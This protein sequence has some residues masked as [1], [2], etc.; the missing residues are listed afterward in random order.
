MVISFWFLDSPPFT[1]KVAQCG[2][3]TMPCIQGA[4][5]ITEERDFQMRSIHLSRWVK[6]QTVGVLFL[7]RHFRSD[8]S[9]FL[10]VLQFWCFLAPG[11]QTWFHPSS[12]NQNGKMWFIQLYLV[13]PDFWL[14]NVL[15]IMHGYIQCIFYMLHHFS[16]STYLKMSASVGFSIPYKVRPLDS[17]VDWYW[18][19]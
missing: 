8:L 3:P 11:F 14:S 2:F 6:L 1:V 18:P 12:E 7:R 13:S 17:W 9:D 10:S 5:G 4:S 16:A 19:A 15:Q